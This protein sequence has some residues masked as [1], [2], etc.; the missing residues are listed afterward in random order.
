MLSA[1]A[2]GGGYRTSPVSPLFVNGRPQDLAMQH[3]RTDIA[4]RSHLR[5]WLSPLQVEGQPVWIGQISRDIGVKV[6][7]LS[8]TLTT[9]VIDP[10]V[11]HARFRLLE[12]LLRSGAMSSRIAQ[13]CVIDTLYAS[14]CSRI[15]NE[16]KPY[17]EQSRVATSRMHRLQG[18]AGERGI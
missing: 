16:V 2:F 18:A 15:F 13:L 9:H 10:Q 14:V 3:A 6:T 4:Q 12:T 5:L 7:T 8:K 11:D 1:F 17:L